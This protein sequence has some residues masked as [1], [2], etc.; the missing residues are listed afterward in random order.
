M[1]EFTAQ[2]HECSI[3]RDLSDDID[4]LNLDGSSPHHHSTDSTMTLPP[5]VWAMVINCKF[6]YICFI[7]TIYCLYIDTHPTLFVFFKTYHTIRS[8]H[9]HQLHVLF[10]MMHYH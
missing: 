9:V 10:Y 2:N 7:S 8:Y 5:E 4:K 1:T 6:V 3:Q